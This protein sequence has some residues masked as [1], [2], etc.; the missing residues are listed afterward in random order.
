MKSMKLSTE[1]PRPEASEYKAPEYPYGLSITLNTE[2]M[3]KLGL[4]MPELGEKFELRAYA[5]VTSTHESKD[6][7][8]PLYQSVSMQIED[9]EV[10]KKSEK[11]DVAK[12]LYDDKD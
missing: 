2:Q 9:L 7:G 8:A 4:A 6:K 11:K 10:H 5:C 3:E 1:E 12:V